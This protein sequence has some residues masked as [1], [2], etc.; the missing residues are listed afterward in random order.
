M[1]TEKSILSSNFTNKLSPSVKEKVNEEIKRCSSTAEPAVESAKCKSNEEK[2]YQESLALY[3][4]LKQE[5]YY[6]HGDNGSDGNVKPKWFDQKLFD[7]G[8]HLG[9]KYFFSCFFGHLCGVYILVQI[10][11]IYETLLTT[12][13]SRTI[14]T[15]FKRYLSTLNHV[16]SWYD[17]D[18]WDPKSPA[19]ESVAAVRKIHKLVSKRVNEGRKEG[20]DK[21]AISQFDMFLTL[22]GFVGN[23]YLHPKET[24]FPDEPGNMKAWLHFW[25]VIGYLMGVDDKYNICD[26]DD[27][28]R[29]GSMMQVVWDQ[30]YK[31]LL[32]NRDPS[33]E[34][35]KIMCDSII[36]SM[37]AILPILSTPGFIKY[38]HEMHCVESPV[39]L[40]TVGAKM[41]H[42]V[43][44]LTMSKLLPSTI[45]EA[46]FNLLLIRSVNR[47]NANVAKIQKNLEG[48]GPINEADSNFTSDS[49]NT[50]MNDTPSNL[51]P[52]S[53]DC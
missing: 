20:V 11:S 8:K 21:V 23:T 28:D 40:E 31:P 38:F 5:G 37:R 46:I 43:L 1:V 35:G 12:G 49:V 26:D 6:I 44:K 19:Y 9:Q 34:K 27:M 45:G 53:S 14:S 10:P 2:L 17:G 7:L 51:D 41:G 18:V 3:K 29:T 50:N 47:C 48:K 30:E 13:N 4:K 24:G 52:I 33:V 36:E 16:K 15:L 22:W 39:E 25:R 42:R 32:I